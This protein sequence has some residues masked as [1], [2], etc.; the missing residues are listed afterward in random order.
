MS[1]VFALYLQTAQSIELRRNPSHLFMIKWVKYPRRNHNKITPTQ[2]EILSKLKSDRLI[3]LVCDVTYGATLRK[4][5]LKQ[6][7]HCS[8][9]A[10]D[11]H[12]MAPSPYSGR[13]E[14]RSSRLKPPNWENVDL[15]AQGV[16]WLSFNSRYSRGLF[17]IFTFGCIRVTVV[18]NLPVSFIVLR[19][20]A[21]PLE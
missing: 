4:A 14:R 11:T 20:V 16:T 10:D 8:Y 21:E 18:L 5:E 6:A 13:R 1:S 15:K 3:C 7:Y 12:K 17:M 9:Y 19:L 2:V